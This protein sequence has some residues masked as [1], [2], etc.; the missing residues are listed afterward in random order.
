MSE[1]AAV[2]AR[3]KREE[4]E[5]CD[6]GGVVVFAHVLAGEVPRLRRTVEQILGLI[7][8]SPRTPETPL[9]DWD[10]GWSDALSAVQE[11]LDTELGG[12]DDA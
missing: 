6:T 7:N 11:V 12:Q 4:D 5:Y 8:E 1:I 3:I 9:T 2:L 10:Q